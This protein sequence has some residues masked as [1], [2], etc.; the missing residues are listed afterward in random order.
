MS[1]SIDLDRVSV[2]FGD[3]DALSNLD[4]HLDGGKIYGLLG[5]NGAGKSTLL[6][7]LG[8]LRLPT[9]GSVKVNGE[10]LFE[11]FPLTQQVCLIRESPDVLD[12][13]E[14]LDYNLEFARAM[15]PNWDEPYARTLIGRFGIPTNQKVGTM[16]RGQRSAV[17]IVIGLAS[18]APLTMF[19]ESYLGLDTPSRYIFYE[20][21]LADFMRVPRTVIV[22]THLIDEVAPMFEETIILDRGRLLLHGE[23][24]ALRARARRFTGLDRQIDTVLEGEILL[25][26]QQLGSTKSA[27]VISDRIDDFEAEGR[28]AGIDV[29]PVGLQDLFVYLTQKEEM[30]GVK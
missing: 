24:D 8:A 16:S 10:E 12:T 17:G 19:D 21:L 29:E 25:G 5:R 27:V 11:N 9:S 4:L 22:S 18:R 2:R 7:L 20:E 26:V 23:T 13:D 6:S 15:R 14:K 28:R 3:K 1:A 30:A